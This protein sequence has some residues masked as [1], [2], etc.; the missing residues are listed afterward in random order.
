MVRD[1]RGLFTRRSGSYDLFI[2]MVRY[3][4]GLRSFFRHSPLLRSDMRVLDAGCGTGAVTLALRAALLSR[5]L[6]PG[7]MQGFDTTPAMLDLFRQRLQRSAINGVELTQGDVL[8]LD[9]LPL[10]WNDYDL[11]VSASMLEYV[12]RDRFVDAVSGLRRLLNRNGR[13]VLFMT[14]RNWLMRPLIGR[15][16]ESHLYTAAEL[17]DA[18][19][20]AGFTTLAFRSFHFPYRYLATWGH[21]VEAAT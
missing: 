10:G 4:Q 11:V 8:R 17:T 2:G 12:P 15:W 3:R 18:F 19:R 14:K 9:A 6:S 13:F 21:I 7:P 16:W 20:Q 1:P 5:G